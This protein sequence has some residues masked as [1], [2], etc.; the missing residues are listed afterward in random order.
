MFNNQIVSMYKKEL[1]EKE[2]ADRNR[3]SE[4]RQDHGQK[5]ERKARIVS[6]T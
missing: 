3:Q 6:T 4:D 2:G 5:Q 1:E